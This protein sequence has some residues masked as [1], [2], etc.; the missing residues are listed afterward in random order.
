L[1]FAA[2]SKKKEKMG[3]GAVT[4]RAEI[5]GQAFRNGLATNASIFYLHMTSSKWQQQ[6]KICAKQT[7]AQAECKSQQKRSQSENL[8]PA[9]TNPP[10]K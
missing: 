5:V 4:W 10:V 3:K 6:P 2:F 9:A 7:S 8:V 1:S